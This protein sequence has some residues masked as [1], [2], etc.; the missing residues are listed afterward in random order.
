MQGLIKNDSNRIGFVLACF[1]AGAIDHQ[2]LRNWAI[3]V[4]SQYDDFPAYFLELI[5]FDQPRFH[6]IQT[7]GFVPVSGL[8]GQALRTIDQIAVQRKQITPDCLSKAD[9]AKQDWI[10][11][12]TVDHFNQEFAEI[13]SPYLR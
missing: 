10:D 3:K 7:I 5:D 12:A 9:L 13:I 11:P 2:E 6:V 4:I 1:L 8:S